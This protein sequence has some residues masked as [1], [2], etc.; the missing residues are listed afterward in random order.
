M[1][2]FI[3]IEIMI[4]GMHD[5]AVLPFHEIAWPMMTNTEKD[6]VVCH[7]HMNHGPTI[8]ISGP[9]AEHAYEDMKKIIT[10]REHLVNGAIT[11]GCE[12]EEPHNLPPCEIMPTISVSTVQEMTDEEIDILLD[13]RAKRSKG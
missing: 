13:E 1:S 5:K 11:E 10:G 8:H 3:A 7:I 4:G 2:E 12:R 6:G 9:G